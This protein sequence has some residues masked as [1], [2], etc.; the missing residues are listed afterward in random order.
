[1][2]K[3]ATAAGQNLLGPGFKSCPSVH[4]IPSVICSHNIWGLFHPF[5]LTMCT[6][7]AIKLFTFI[8][9]FQILNVLNASCILIIALNEPCLLVLISCYFD[10]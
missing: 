3:A 4:G 9:V 6:G 8:F 10:I 2:T 7:V 5:V 1:M